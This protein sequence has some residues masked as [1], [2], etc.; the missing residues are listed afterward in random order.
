MKVAVGVGEV[1]VGGKFPRISKSF[2]VVVNRL[3]LGNQSGK[4]NVFSQMNISLAHK[5]SLISSWLKKTS[6]P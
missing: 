4:D 6:Q 2:Q 3:I 1:M 5:N